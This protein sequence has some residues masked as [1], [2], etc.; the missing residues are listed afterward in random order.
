MRSISS[1]PLGEGNEDAIGFGMGTLID[2]LPDTID[3]AFR[4]ERNTNSVDISLQCRLEDVR[5]AGP[6]PA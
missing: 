6:K 3:A 5:T 4:L 2:D 1:L